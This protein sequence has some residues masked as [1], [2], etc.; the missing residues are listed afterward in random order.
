LL[1]AVIAANL[2]LAG[3]IG[4][5]LVRDYRHDRDAAVTALE[6]LSRILDDNLS[7]LIEKID[8]TLL[9]TA[10]EAESELADGGIERTKFE[11]FLRRHDARLPEAGGL[12]VSNTAGR[13]VYAVNNVQQPNFDAFDRE[14]FIRP[15]DDP[16]AGLF[17]SAPLVG[18]IFTHSMIILSRRYRGADGS[19]AGVVSVAL[20]IAS[21]SGILSATDVL[22]PNA[23][24]ALWDS[25]FGLVA[26]YAQSR[27]LLAEG[28]KPSPKL[29]E[30]ITGNSKP[31]VIQN[32][33]PEFGE[34]SR[35]VFFR[36]ISRWPLFV[37]V[38]VPEE[39]IM[40]EWWRELAALGFLGGLFLVG[41]ASAFAVLKRAL[42]A[43]R[44]S[45][46]RYRSLFE[47]MHGGFTLR[48][49][50]TDAAG[51]AVDVRFLAANKA[52]L[53][54]FGLKPDDVIGRTM[55]Q[56]WPDL[57][58]NSTDW[59]GICAEVARSGEPVRFESYG[60]VTRR[61]FQQ[62]AYRTGPMQV[63]VLVY[64]ITERK[65]AEAKAQRLSNL[66]AALSQ[67][68][69]SIVRVSTRED[70]FGEI[71]RIAIEFGHFH[72]A[73]I[74]LI[75]EEKMVVVPF[76]WAGK[77]T[78]FL[79]GLLVSTDPASPFN[80]GPTG[81]AGA[82]GQ[83]SI[84]NDIATSDDQTPRHPKIWGLG[85]RSTG[86][87][88]LLSR[89]RVIGTLT[90]YSLETNF[91][92]DDL[93]SLLQEMATDISFALDRM[94]AEAE[95]RRLEQDL[96]VTSARIHGVIE[97]SRDIIATTDTALRF[98]GFNRAY[99]DLYRRLFGKD[100]HPGMPV[101]EAFGGEEQ[102]AARFL[103]NWRKALA[104]EQATVEWS[105][106][107]GET[108]LVYD[109]RYGPLLGPSGEQIG[110]FLVGRDITLRKEAER[111]LG[112]NE[113]RLRLAL[114]AAQQGWFELDLQTGEA[115]SSPEYVR[116]LGFDPD[117][118]STD[119]KTWQEN[120]HPDDVAGVLLKYEESLEP[121]HGL[122]IEYRRR[123]KSGEWRWLRTIGRVVAWDPGG[124]PL[125]MSGI[126]MDVTQRK[127]AEAG[128]QLAASVFTEANE[129]IMITDAQGRIVDVNEAFSRLTGYSRD[130]AIG[131][132]P[133]LL[134][135][136]RQTA[137]YYAAMW[138][139]LTE[140]GHWYGELWNRRKDGSV[141]AEKL[142]I[143]AVR[144]A[145]GRTQNYVAL[146]TDITAMKEYQHQLEH[147][148]HYDIL[149]N[150]P[151]RVL[152]A[153]R[154]QQGIAQSERRGDIVAVGYLDLDGFK[155]INDKYGH[156][157]GD[158]LLVAVAT[159]VKAVLRKGDTLA[160]IGGDE[161][162]AVLP[163][164]ER[165]EDC[166][167]MIGRLLAAAN[168]PVAINDT[169]LQVSASIGVSL[170]PQD[171]SS[172][173]LLVRHADQAMYSAKQAGRNC[174]RVFDVERDTVVKTQAEGLRRI[175]MA[176]DAREFVLH[177][178]PKVNMKTGTVIGA[179]ALIRWQHPERGLLSPAEFLPVIEGDPINVELGE[180]VLDTALTEVSEWRKAGLDIPVSV[181]VAARQL[182]HSD[183]VSSLR[184]LLAAHPD[185]PPSYLELEILETS[186]L[187]DIGVVTKL[188]RTCQEMGVRFA[189]DDFG[190][191][192]SSLTYLRRLPAELVKIDQTFVGDMLESSDDLAIVDGVVGLAQAFGREVIAEGVET[193]AHGELL[194]K[195]GCE[196]G[197]GYGIARPM[198]AADLL[199][200]VTNWQADS[201]ELPKAL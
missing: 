188:M 125:K 95:R 175:R 133:R 35:F 15:R 118:F 98:T 21:L 139:S 160:R 198:P 81:K 135:S 178:Q 129:G 128:L 194:L 187:A 134:K 111:R 3:I 40:G 123:T 101:A 174:Y 64:D 23:R 169:S 165:P 166:H 20:P 37:T 171:P 78:S 173:D 96:I 107:E 54:I 90:L 155:E 93:V 5:V 56:I 62:T 143:S 60:M 137:D 124:K 181:N 45:E 47:H 50:I 33:R 119:F 30:L 68:N 115:L 149:T 103:E 138:R 97:C 146:F 38:G 164:L 144:D 42:G 148:A 1:V 8:L 92:S 82:T 52:Y 116:M 195:L 74:G 89:N 190:T 163:D 94:D 61:W 140:E 121:G 110:A 170:Y 153:D 91:F 55:L 131:S 191:G 51:R 176:L 192:Y 73:W 49:I 179:E 32:I 186:A 177:F 157:V 36:K 79:D 199:A 201:K 105:Y 10:E 46:N 69:Q 70:L 28:T 6:H 27:Y 34:S 99:G 172:P 16:T 117:S 108:S 182:Q 100:I 145:A 66:Y 22:G 48:E 43:L 113:T 180:W 104:G 112:E 39:E 193:A 185:V 7:R 168:T 65:S 14:Y 154:L 200:W 120:L 18:R 189:L 26:Q 71:C 67:T 102:L 25:G 109:S 114:E 77:D 75:D 151:N 196:L 159:H 150:L 58:K 183:F 57:A 29:A 152:L 19:F 83:Y 53:A 24:A 9:A 88:P 11:A 130:E 2:F 142:T 162:V 132:S 63:A 127:Q 17:I 13:I 156:N 158:E 197:Q 147:M 136:G 167:S 84:M 122:D 4:S 72:M 161:F 126:H 41:S 86:A 59:I 184:N 80:A 31:T 85:I 141:F 44:A 12:R 87:F 76:K 106:G